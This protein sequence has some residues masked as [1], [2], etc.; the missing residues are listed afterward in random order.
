MGKA[1]VKNVRN[2]YLRGV[3]T[4]ARLFTPLAPDPP[5]PNAIQWI[6]PLFHPFHKQV[7]TPLIHSTFSEITSGI[8]PLIHSIHTP[9]YYGD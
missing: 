9:Y 7:F 6:P 8:Q 3:Q 2:L 4:C 1:W 5:S